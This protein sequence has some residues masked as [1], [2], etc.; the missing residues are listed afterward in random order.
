MRKN[1][2]LAKTLAPLAICFVSLAAQ[3]SETPEKA[4]LNEAHKSLE[5][6]VCHGTTSPQ[7]Q[8]ANDACLA[9]HGSFDALVAKTS[10]YALNPHDSPHWGAEIPC[11]TCHKQHAK[12]VVQC[13]ACHTNQNYRAR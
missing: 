13:A 4:V 8:P 10:G 6:A 7:N 11:G 2:L 9:C 5:C 1:S 12:P 3:A